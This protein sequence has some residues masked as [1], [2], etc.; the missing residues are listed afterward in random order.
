MDMDADRS[1][2]IEMLKR[3]RPQGD[4]D[5]SMIGEDED[6]LSTLDNAVY[7]HG[8]LDSPGERE[9]VS[10]RRLDFRQS[11]ATLGYD[12]GYWGGD[13]YS[14]IADTLVAPTWHGPPDSAYAELAAVLS[15]L[16]SHL[17]F[18]TPADAAAFRSYYLTK[19]WAETETTEGEFCIIQV[20][21]V[22]VPGDLTRRWIG[23]RA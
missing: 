6:L 2:R 23:P 20:D 16:N 5:P 12:V 18:P 17:L 19:E 3:L 7:V 13:H 4:A 1:A 8:L 9:V 14:L 11:E 22:D 10:V 21:A 15:P